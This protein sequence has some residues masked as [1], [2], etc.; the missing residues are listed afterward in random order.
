MWRRDPRA[1]WPPSFWVEGPEEAPCSTLEPLPSGPGS[2]TCGG[3][4]PPAGAAGPL[5]PGVL[6]EQLAF[7]LHL[8]SQEAQSPLVALLQASARHMAHGASG[9]PKAPPVPLPPQGMPTAHLAWALGT[10]LFPPERQVSC[11]VVGQQ[12]PHDLPASGLAE[13]TP[14]RQGSQR[15]PRPMR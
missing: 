6:P 9:S 3:R 5:L 13:V 4:S 8:R 2:A 11:S 12:R 15:V 1:M 14:H 10:R 7:H